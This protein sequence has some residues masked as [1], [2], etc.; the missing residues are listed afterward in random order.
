MYARVSEPEPPE[1]GYL[2]GAGSVTLARLHLKYLFNN[3]RKLYGTLPH[4]MSFLK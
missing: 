3:S 4:L 2:A 1:L